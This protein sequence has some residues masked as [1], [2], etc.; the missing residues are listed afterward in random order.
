MISARLASLWIIAAGVHLALAEQPPKVSIVAASTPGQA[1]R[2]GIDEIAAA[3]REKH[4]SFEITA[5]PG[6]AK[7]DTLLI[8]GLANDRILFPVSFDPFYRSVPPKAEAR[9]RQ[10]RSG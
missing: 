6:A 5:T 9:C 10:F 1:A 2:H 7:G 8:A 4:I 3:L